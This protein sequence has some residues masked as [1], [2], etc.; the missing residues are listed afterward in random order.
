MQIAVTGGLGFIGRNLATYFAKNTGDYQLHGVDW[1]ENARPQDFEGFSSLTQTCFTSKAALDVLIQ[2]DVIVHLAATTTVA[3][4]IVDPTASFQN[5]V[6]K[7]Q[8]LLEE[9]RNKNPDCHF[10]FA[11]TGGAIIGDY[12]APIHENL[13]SRPLSPYG[14]T[15]LAVEG[16]LSAY[17][18]SYGMTTTALR[19]SNVY[20][21]KSERKTSV[22][23]AFCKAYVEDKSINVHGD[24][25]QTRDYVHVED[26][27]A[28]INSVV[29]NRASGVFQLGTGLGTS[30]NDVLA[31]LQNSDL[32]RRIDVRHCPEKPGEVRHNLCDITHAKNALG[33]DPQIRLPEGVRQTLD[34]YH[35]HAQGHS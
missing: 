29:E 35:N 1:F 19:F 14:A 23:S 22:I 21:P 11:S 26:I 5:N 7:T 30:V 3:N 12:A 28:G 2:A 18:G 25:K 27:C 20:G 4:S 10:I 9:L 15:K 6:V 8:T 17:S 33:F 34:W 16:M 32:S 13:A 24:G 31:L